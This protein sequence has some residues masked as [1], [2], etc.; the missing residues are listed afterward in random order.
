MG[1]LETRW[2]AQSENLAALTDLSGLWINV[3]PNIGAAIAS[4]SIWIRAS[5]CA[6]GKPRFAP[7][8]PPESGRIRAILTRNEDPNGESQLM[9]E[10]ALLKASYC[11]R[12][13]VIGV[14][15]E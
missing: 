5:V 10:K 9:A 4:C 6:S 14:C 8:R 13:W 2:L 15:I 3:L 1:R 11:F 12:N 7:T